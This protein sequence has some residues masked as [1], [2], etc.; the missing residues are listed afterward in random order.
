MSPN[1]SS[2]GLAVLE[3]R[4]AANRGDLPRRRDRSQD[5]EREADL[6]RAAEGWLDFRLIYYHHD[7]DRRGDEAGV[8][9]LLICH[10]G[11]FVAVELKAKR[12]KLR[13]EQLQAMAAIRRAG[14]R[15][16]VARSLEEFIRKLNTQA[17]E[18][19]PL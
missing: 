15:V 18:R 2:A 13:P 11:Q 12:G 17:N 19:N 7:R 16:F 14:G 8:P 4:L 6:Q 3:A 10:E 9:D 5:E 1:I